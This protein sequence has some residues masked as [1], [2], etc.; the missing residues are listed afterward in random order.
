[1]KCVLSEITSQI[2]QPDFTPIGQ[3]NRSELENRYADDNSSENRPRPAA[4]SMFQTNESRFWRSLRNLDRT[5]L[6]VRWEAGGDCVIFPDDV[7]DK[8]CPLSGSRGREG[9]S[10][11]TEMKC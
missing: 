8:F 1:M 10:Q 11:G 3:R 2:A 5:L 7:D 4:K 6:R 9:S